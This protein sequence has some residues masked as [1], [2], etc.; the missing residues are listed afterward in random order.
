MS[1]MLIELQ[2]HYSNTVLIHDIISQTIEST[3]SEHMHYMKVKD[4]FINFA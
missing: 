3:I 1:F 4:S 2:N